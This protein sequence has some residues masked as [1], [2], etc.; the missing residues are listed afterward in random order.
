MPF[1]SITRLRLRA[2]R[3]LPVFFLHALRAQRQLRHAP[4]FLGGGLLPDRCR[5]FWT[6]SVWDDAQ[7]MRTYILSGDHE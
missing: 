6:M 2:V 1:V 7:S 4:G 5:T 3:F